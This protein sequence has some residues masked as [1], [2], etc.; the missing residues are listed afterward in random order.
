MYE[1]L[2]EEGPRVQR[3]RYLKVLKVPFKYEL[4]SKE[5]PSC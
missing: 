2:V 4:A 1:K 5:G 3:T